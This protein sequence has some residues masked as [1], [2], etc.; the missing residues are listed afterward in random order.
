MTVIYRI[1]TNIGQTNILRFAIKL[2]LAKIKF[3]KMLS[4]KIGGAHEWCKNDAIAFC[5][6]AEMLWI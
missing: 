1:I 2:Q 3:G 6:C 5:G 4:L